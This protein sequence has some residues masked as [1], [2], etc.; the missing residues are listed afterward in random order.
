[1]T[2]DRKYSDLTYQIIGCAMEVHSELGGG[3][4][5]KVYENSLILAFEEK[6]LMAIAQHPLNVKYHEKVVG[7]YY[8][9]IIIEDKI[10]IE[11]KA[12]KVICD[13][14]RAQIINYLHA[15]TSS[16]APL[17]LHRKAHLRL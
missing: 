5:E 17:H 12:V 16:V 6:G 2:E 15:T 8:A 11:L 13:E 10:I 4:L 14:H 9:D 7:E 3:F 1:M